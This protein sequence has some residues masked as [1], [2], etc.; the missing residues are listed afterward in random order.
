MCVW[1]GP[2]LHAQEQTGTA[3]PRPQPALPVTRGHSNPGSVSSSDVLGVGSGGD[4]PLA[5]VTAR[6]TKRDS[7]KTSARGHLKEGPLALGCTLSRVLPT[8]PGQS[9]QV[10]LPSPSWMGKLSAAE[11]NHSAARVRPSPGNA[12]KPR[13]FWVIKTAPVA[14]D[15]EAAGGWLASEQGPRLGST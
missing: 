10:V 3:G 2:H 7:P 6:S 13:H 12:S 1:G 4:F 11:R 5:C 9:R 15:P 14:A 8:L